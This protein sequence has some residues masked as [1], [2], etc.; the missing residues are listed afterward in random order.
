MEDF[1]FLLDWSGCT[2]SSGKFLS[3]RSNEISMNNALSVVDLFD[4]IIVGIL[5]EQVLRNVQEVSL[6]LRIIYTLT[7]L[8]FTT[9]STDFISGML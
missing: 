3:L 7:S 9:H 1:I 8:T 5:E 4:S 6:P 2:C